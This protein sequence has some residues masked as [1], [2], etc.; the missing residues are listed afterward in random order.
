M[1]QLGRSTILAVLALALIVSGCNLRAPLGSAPQNAWETLCASFTRED[2][3]QYNNATLQMKYLSNDCVMFEFKLMTG[4]ESEEWTDELVLPFV[5]LVDEDTGVG[6]YESDP[7]A[8]K[9]I[10]IEFNLSK[11]G[12]QVKVT[13]TGELP[14]S[15]DGV[16]NFVDYNIEVSESSAIAILEHLPTAAT[17]LNSNNG[18]YSIQYPDELIADWFYPVEVTFDDTGAVLAKFLIAKDLS[19]F[20]RVD[21]DIEPILI[22]GSA[23]H[24]M[25]AENIPFNDDKMMSEQPSADEEIAERVDESLPVVLVKLEDDVPLKIGA[26]SQ[27]VAVRPWPLNYTLTAESSDPSLV[28]VDDNGAVTAVAVG[29]STIN[30]TIQIDDGKKHFSVDVSVSENEVS[31]SVDI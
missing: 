8:K 23:Q 25:D 26:T 16:Y 14:I 10:T 18:A 30:G 3:S 13:H 15:P 5:L 31:G 9:P 2:S 6:R 22:F 20:Y 24:M 21:D 11:D 27:L 12:R 28:T 19:A 7:D 1:K 4:S 17:S 29:V